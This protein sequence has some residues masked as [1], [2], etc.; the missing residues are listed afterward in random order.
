MDW[1]LMDGGENPV[2]REETVY[3]STIF[4]YIAIL[5]DLSLRF[6]WVATI[7][8]TESAGVSADVLSFIT[9][10]LEV[11]RRFMWNFLRLENEHLNN[12]GN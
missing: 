10:P 8:L 7:S 1:G 6:V 5:E 9:A 12:C 2:L 11:F 4:Y 3:P